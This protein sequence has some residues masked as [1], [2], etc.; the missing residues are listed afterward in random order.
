MVNVGM[1][2]HW[3]LLIQ[4]REAASAISYLHQCGII[5]G[6][7]KASNILVSDDV[8]ALLCDFGLA[9]FEDMNTSIGQKGQGTSRFQSPELMQLG[10]GKSP[11]S[12][13]WAFGM[14]IYQVRR[15]ESW[16]PCVDLLLT[17]TP[18]F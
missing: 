17:Y 2:A 14:T 13:V 3:V 18:R 5:H 9:R 15:Q 16:G 11:E 12:D 4:L 8:H 7:I 10:Q 6:D 1:L